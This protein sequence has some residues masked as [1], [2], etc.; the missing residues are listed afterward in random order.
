ME[1]WNYLEKYFTWLEENKK[2][3]A[4]DERFIRIKKALKHCTSKAIFEFS[5]CMMKDIEP[6]V[7]LFQAE[8]PMA[9]FL[10]EN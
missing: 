9:V 10:Y 6:F 3:P 5:L 2:F 7:E 8:R 1:I 4:K